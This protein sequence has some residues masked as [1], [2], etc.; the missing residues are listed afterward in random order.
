MT[1]TLAEP[2]PTSKPKQLRPF[3]LIVTLIE[4]GLALWALSSLVQHWQ[5]RDGPLP[6]NFG[7]P[8]LS[9]VLQV[10]W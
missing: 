4:L 7:A 1:E 3:A 5:G 2:A 6:P 9:F 10:A 8:W